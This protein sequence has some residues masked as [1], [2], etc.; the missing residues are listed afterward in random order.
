M[1]LCLVFEFFNA[2]NDDLCNKL[3]KDLKFLTSYEI[4]NDYYEINKFENK[5]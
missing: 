5:I 4:F 3:G 2:F 1:I